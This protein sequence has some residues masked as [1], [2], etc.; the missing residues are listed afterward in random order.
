MCRLRSQDRRLVAPQG[1]RVRGRLHRD[2]SFRAVRALYGRARFRAG[3]QRILGCPD[4]AMDYPGS[5]DSLTRGHHIWRIAAGCAERPRLPGDSS[6]NTGMEWGGNVKARATTRFLWWCVAFHA[7]CRRGCTVAQ[8]QQEAGHEVW[9]SACHFQSGPGTAGKVCWL[10]RAATVRA[11][12]PQQRAAEPRG[13]VG[14]R[15]ARRFAA[16]LRRASTRSFRRGPSRGRR[17]KAEFVGDDGG[18][19]AQ[20]RGDQS[21]QVEVALAGGGVPG[22][23]AEDSRWKSGGRKE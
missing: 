14:I 4:G 23:L 6:I 9:A 19:G 2:D 21:G 8:P 15:P 17:R 11:P 3:L 1:S 20:H 10:R 22:E 16:G 5:S 13:G 18:G 12:L 7:G